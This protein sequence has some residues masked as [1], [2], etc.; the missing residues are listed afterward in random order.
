VVSAQV[1][2]DKPVV[3]MSVV[4][5][6]GGETRVTA[7][8]GALAPNEPLICVKGYPKTGCNK[9]IVTDDRGSA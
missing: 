3:G 2:G 9:A 4:T 8:G 5:S 7:I 6:Y 1:P